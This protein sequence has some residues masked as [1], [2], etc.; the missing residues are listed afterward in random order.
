MKVQ[1]ILSATDKQGNYYST[2]YG[3]FGFCTSFGYT[4]VISSKGNC[5]IRFDEE[6]CIQAC[7]MD[8]FNFKMPN[9]NLS[10]NNFVRELYKQNVLHEAEEIT[11]IY[12]WKQISVELKVGG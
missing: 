8:D 5:L 11:D 12:N 9:C 6:D 10:I 7:W 4:Y 3:V 2:M 1:N